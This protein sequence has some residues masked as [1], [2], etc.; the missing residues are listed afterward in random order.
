M[1]RHESRFA[2]W[3]G[4]L[5]R[6]QLSLNRKAD[7][8]RSPIASGQARGVLFIAAAAGVLAAGIRQA[9]TRRCRASYSI[10]ALRNHL[11]L[12]AALAAIGVRATFFARRYQTNQPSLSR[13]DRRLA[14]SGK[15][16]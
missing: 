14:F 9:T 4:I 8:K 2:G 7:E 6:K 13:V 12:K 15:Y 5:N 11:G 3:R 1:I 16:P 10:N